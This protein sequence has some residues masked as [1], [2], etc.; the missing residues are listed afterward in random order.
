MQAAQLRFEALPLRRQDRILLLLLRFA[1]HIEPEFA[2]LDAE[3]PGLQHLLGGGHQVKIRLPLRGRRPLAAVDADPAVSL[4]PQ[5]GEIRLRGDARIHHHGGLGLVRTAL[6]AQARDCVR[7]RPAFGHVPRQDLASPR[8][9]GTVQ[10]QRR[11]DQRAV[12]APL[13]RA[14][15]PAQRAVGEAATA[16]IGQIVEHD[17]VRDPEQRR[18]L[19]PQSL[20]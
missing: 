7:Q 20:L 2:V 15:P 5:P 13:L 1:L 8:K 17:R 10:H 3:A 4:L 6:L 12:V 9:A 11:G 19:L 14:S 16:G 18:F